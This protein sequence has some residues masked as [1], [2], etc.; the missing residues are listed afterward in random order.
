MFRHH[1]NSMLLQLRIRAVQEQ[2]DVRRALA[3]ARTEPHCLQELRLGLQGAEPSERLIP[4]ACAR[5][6]QALAEVGGVSGVDFQSSLKC[7]LTTWLSLTPRR[8]VSWQ[9]AA[10]RS[11]TRSAAITCS[12]MGAP[13]GPQ[14]AAALPYEVDK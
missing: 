11:V 12:G 5:L 13:A 7:E 3:P 2:R 10:C 6:T 8:R 14:S 4:A 1:F 9:C